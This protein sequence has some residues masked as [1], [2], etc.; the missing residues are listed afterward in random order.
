LTKHLC[1]RVKSS[2]IK[3]V[4]TMYNPQRGVWCWDSQTRNLCCRKHGVCESVLRSTRLDGCIAS[5]GLSNTHTCP[6]I[7]G[8]AVYRCEE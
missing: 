6:S 7:I 5:P 3:E 8:N 2:Y 1:A 4:R